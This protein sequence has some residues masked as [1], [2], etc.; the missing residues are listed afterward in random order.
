MAAGEALRVARA[1]EEGEM[2]LLA[3]SILEAVRSDVIAEEAVHAVFRDRR[4]RPTRLR[5]EDTVALATELTG[6]MR[7][8]RDEAPHGPACTRV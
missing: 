8:R 4:A 5:G 1:R 6:A 3:E 2:I 7:V